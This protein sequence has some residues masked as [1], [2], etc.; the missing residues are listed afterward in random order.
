MNPTDHY[1]PLSQWPAEL[2]P[3]AGFLVHA[4]ALLRAGGHKHP[5]R[6][7]RDALALAA[8]LSGYWRPTELG[9][10]INVAM[11]GGRASPRRNVIKE[12]MGKKRREGLADLGLFI[13]DPPDG[14][15][16]FRIVLTAEGEAAVAAY[17][18]TVGVPTSPT[19]EVVPEI[20]EVENVASGYTRRSRAQGFGLSWL[21]RHAVEMHAMAL[22]KAHFENL[23]WRVDNV[24]STHPYDFECTRGSEE[25]IV[26]VKGTTSTG[27]QIVIT[28]NE[29]AVQRARHPNN[30][31]I[32]VHSI[33]L[34]RSAV[35]PKVNGGELLIF[36][37]W[38]IDE[39]RLRPLVFQ[40]AVR[41]DEL[42]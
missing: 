4:F 40:Y 12:G 26:E 31:L 16:P 30:A 3:A 19:P 8:H 14:R 25:L 9:K 36:C 37:P 11:G 33:N 28:R 2:R 23:G 1:Q 13:R 38:T 29:V 39:G 41:L 32:V 20:L 24:S 34:T 27:E 10:A 7:K 42:A 17:C 22:A 5:E 6:N 35:D 15:S 18:A 21:E